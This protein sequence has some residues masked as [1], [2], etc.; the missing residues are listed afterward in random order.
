MRASGPSC[1]GSTV[2]SNSARQNGAYGLDLAAGLGSGYSGNTI[3]GNT[4]G[5]VTGGVEMG[6]NV[7]DANTTCP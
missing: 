4:T 7:C 2:T 6:T 3:D 1:W 5:T